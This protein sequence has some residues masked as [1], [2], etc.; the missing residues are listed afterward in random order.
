[1]TGWLVGGNGLILKT[2]TGGVMNVNQLSNEIPNK[3]SLH[4]NYPN[5][6]N[7]S[8]KIRFDLH[9]PIHAKL[10][11]FNVLGREVSTLVDEEL[12]AGSYEVNFSALSGGSSYPSGVY[13]YRLET[14]NF[15]ETKR[16][17]LLK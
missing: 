17:V 14:N 8:T 15:S 3:F 5:P 11:V 10:I 1:M 16:M 7:P 9:K 13:F 12:R 2:V 6:F 4:Q